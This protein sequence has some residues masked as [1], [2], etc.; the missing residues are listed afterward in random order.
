MKYLLMAFFCYRDR[1]EHEMREIENQQIKDREKERERIER[2]R[3]REK[4]EREQQERER[5][6][7]AVHKHFEESLRLANQKVIKLY[8]FYCDLVS[9]K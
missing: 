9:I 3:E 2:E 7:K 8:Y 4:L 5:Q 1:R 6:E